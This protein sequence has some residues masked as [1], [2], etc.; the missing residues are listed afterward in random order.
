MFVVSD[1]AYKP[2][3]YHSSF[4]VTQGQI[5]IPKEGMPA[6]IVPLETNYGYAIGGL[7]F[8]GATVVVIVC[9]AK[10]RR[11]RHGV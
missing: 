9:V 3:M 11:T 8:A 1:A 2:D 4:L 7:I 6:G 10:K 5:Q